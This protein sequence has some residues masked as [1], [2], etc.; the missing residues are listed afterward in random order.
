LKA[1]I[2]REQGAVSYLGSDPN[3]VTVVDLTI[4]L[5]SDEAKFVYE[6]LRA[7]YKRIY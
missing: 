2:A 7:H 1:K 3:K 5:T 4:E 6:A